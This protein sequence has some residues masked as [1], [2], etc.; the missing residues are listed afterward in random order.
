MEPVED[1]KKRGVFILFEGVDRCG[2]TTQSQLLTK[3]LNEKTTCPTE[4]IR[5]PARETTIGQIIDSYLK[6][7]N[8]LNDHSIHLLFSANRWERKKFIEESLA[9]GRS[10]VSVLIS[11]IIF[12][13]T[14]D[15]YLFMFN[16]RF[17]IVML[18]AV[19]LL[20]QLKDWIFNGVNPAT[21]VFL[22]LMPLF[23]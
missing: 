16:R 2:K 9:K 7:Q 11:S 18:I 8:D 3:Y 23:I 20:L 22:P 6:S 17:V 15:S 13:L 14:Q 1:R 10:F 12:L 19:W 5:F 21:W 4:L